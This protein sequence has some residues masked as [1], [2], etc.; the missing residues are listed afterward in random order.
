FKVRAIDAAGNIDSSPATHTW[1]IDATPPAPPVIVAIS[2]D[3]G[4]VNNDK[5]TSDNTLKLSGTSE[6]NATITIA[7]TGKGTIG[8]AQANSSGNWEFNYEGTALAAGNHTF[9][10]TAADALGNTSTVG[11]NFAVTIDLTAPSVAITSTESSPVNGPFEIS[12]KFSEAVYGLAAADVAVTNGTINNLKS[13]D[14]AN[15]TATITP[16]ADG[17]VTVQLPDAKVTDLAGN[18]NT[19]SDAF[20]MQYD[21]TK[22]TIVLSTN[23][24]ATINTAFEVTIT[25]SEPVT[26]LDVSD[27]TVT[28]GT[29]TELTKRDGKTYT[30]LISPTVQ[31]E[32][33]VTIAANKTQDAAKNGNEASNILKR[34]FDSVAPAGYAVAFGVEQVD[35]TNEKNVALKITGS[36]TGASYVYTITSNNGGDPVTGTGEATAA[37]INIP[38]LDLSGL[39]DGTLTVTVYLTDKAGNKGDN[40]TAQVLKATKDIASVTPTGELKVPFNTDFSEIPLPQKVKVTYNT[41]EE[42]YLDVTWQ[43][44]NYNQLVAGKYTISGDLKLADNTTNF[45]NRKGTLI[46]EVEPNRPPTALTLSISKFKPEAEP[47]EVLGTFTTEDPDDEVFTYRLIAGE[48]DDQNSYFFIQDNELHLTSNKGLSGVVTFKIRVESKDPYNN[49]IEQTFTL[50]KS[51]YEPQEKIK[52]VNA[53]SPDGDGVNDTWTVPELRFY[54]EVEI[55]VMDRAGVRLYQ[56]T[57]PEKGWDGKGKNGEVQQGAYFYIIHVKDTGLV[58]KGVLTVL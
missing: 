40:A 48:G 58:Q 36:E 47:T 26:G 43:K 35:I 19:A 53:F 37:T 9:T 57:D 17:N 10:A 12:I 14:A 32:V 25:L 34:T 42:D 7:L 18:N 3:R 6:A 46:I 4:P 45:S 49:T 41:G 55:T 13:T 22:P 8:T 2:E 5:I 50:T 54:N 27:V 16:S 11:S 23:A 29:A 28:N 38:G 24:A 1:T 33:S 51:V 44:G 30:V 39:K 31:G 21:V 15:Y 20:V 52:L 56:S